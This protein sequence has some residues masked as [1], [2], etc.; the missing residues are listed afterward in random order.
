M[1]PVQ[2]DEGGEGP[3]GLDLLAVSR[4]DLRTWALDRRYLL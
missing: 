3:K 1:H 2:E 4:A